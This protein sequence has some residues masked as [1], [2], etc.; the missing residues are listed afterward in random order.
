MVT[1]RDFARAQGQQVKPKGGIDLKNSPTQVQV[2]SSPD[3]ENIMLHTL[4]ATRRGGFPP[5]VRQI[6]M[7]AAIENAGYHTKSLATSAVGAPQADA[8][9]VPGALY[10]GHR[11][12]WE[13][14]AGA[15]TIEFFFRTDDLTTAHVGNGDPAPGTH[16]PAPAGQSA[17]YTIKLRPILSKGPIKRTVDQASAGPTASGAHM[18]WQTTNRWGGAAA[19]HAMPFLFALRN[20]TSGGVTVWK[21]D[22]CHHAFD[23]GSGNWQLIVVT[24]TIFTIEP[25]IT[26]HCIGSYNDAVGIARLRVGQLT[27]AQTIPTYTYDTLSYGPFTKALATPTPIQVFDCPMEIMDAPIT[28]T[29]TVPPGL[30]NVARQ[31]GTYFF[32]AKRFEGALE[33]ITVHVGDVL[34]SV[35]STLDRSTKYDPMA[36]PATVRQHW[37]FTQP[38]MDYVQE[39][40]GQ[41]NHLYFSPRGPIFDPLSG[42][43]RPAGSWWFNGQTSYALAKLGR[44][45]AGVIGSDDG[46][47]NWRYQVTTRDEAAM[48]A[49]VH[50]NL[51][52]G[53]HVV[54]T[55]DS[56]HESFEQVIAEMHSVL[57]VA[58]NTDGTIV[59]YCR[60]SSTNAGAIAVPVYQATRVQSSGVVKAGE[61]YEVTLLR[62]NA[63]LRLRL[64]IN[65]ALDGSAVVTA[66]NVDSEP[67]SGL[68]I[69]AGSFR[70]TTYTTDIATPI[71]PSADTGTNEDINTDHRSHFCGRVEQVAV[72]VGGFKLP[73]VYTDPGEAEVRIEQAR[74]WESPVGGPTRTILEPD[75]PNDLVSQEI[76]PG[77]VVS[78]SGDI[79]INAPIR[80]AIEDAGTTNPRFYST[81][82]AAPVGEE[83]LAF[84]NGGADTVARQVIAWYVLGRWVL[85][86]DDRDERDHGR[87]LRS[88]ELRNHTTTG[89]VRRYFNEHRAIHVQGS[90]CQDDL[91][92]LAALQKRCVESDQLTEA[93]AQFTLAPWQHRNRPFMWKHPTELGPKWAEGIVFPRAD[94]N[95]ITLL[96][97]FEPEKTGERLLIAAASRQLYWVRD[98]WRLDSPFTSEVT[99]RVPFGFGSP[100]SHLRV[101]GTVSQQ[102]FQRNSGNSLEI[103][104]WLKP[105]NLHGWRTLLYKGNLNGRFNF[106]VFF[107]D[108]SLNVM[109]TMG[110][111]QAFWLREGYLA[112]GVYVP[113]V[114]MMVNRWNEIT[115][116]M[117]AATNTI[118]AVVN[119]LAVTFVLNPG[120]TALGTSANDAANYTLYLMGVPLDGYMQ[121]ITYASPLVQSIQFAGFCG[122]VTDVSIRNVL[123]SGQAVSR[124]RQVDG[125]GT[126]YLLPLNE[127]AG[128]TVT[129][130]AALAPGNGE[131]RLDELVL[132]K[133][134]LDE[135]RGAPYR[136]VVYRDRLYVTNGRSVPTSV[137]FR[138]FSHPE[139]AFSVQRV[140]MRQPHMEINVEQGFRAGATYANGVYQ[141][142]LAFENE[143]GIL[144]EPA[145]IVTSPSGGTFNSLYMNRLPRSFDPQVVARQFYLNASGGGGAPLLAAR[146]PDNESWDWEIAPPTQGLAVEATGRKLPAPRA[147]GITVGQGSL[148]LIDLTELDAGQ[149]AF[150]VSDGE[151]VIWWPG[152]LV[153]FVDSRDGKRI[154]SIEAQLG[155]VYLFKRDSSWNE[156]LAGAS[157]PV[158][159][160]VNASVGLAGGVTIYDNLL[161]GAGDKGVYAFDGTSVQYQSLALEGDYR[162]IIDLDDEGLRAMSGAYW[163]PNSQYWISMRETGRDSN[164]LIYVLHTDIG[165]QIG[166]QPQHAWTKLRVPEHTAMASL[167]D[168]RRKPILLLGTVG[169]QILKYDEDLL[170]DG[171]AGEGTLLG[172]ATST[173]LTS[174]T[175]I[176]ATFDTKL[177]GLR[178]AV[179]EITDGA[180]VYTRTIERNTATT[181]FWIDPIAG[182][183]QT[184]SFLIGGFDSFWTTPWISLARFGSF[185]KAQQLD[186]DYDPQVSSLL[187]CHLQAVSGAVT[188]Q[189]TFPL[190]NS[191]YK[192][193]SLDSGYMESPFRITGANRGRFVRLRFGQKKPLM[194]FSVNAWQIRGEES[195]QR[196]GRST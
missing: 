126:Y 110:S 47:P 20:F 148:W 17:P 179:V 75:D 120:W 79:Q 52:H 63:G 29:P 31:D 155:R 138:R 125:A 62:D 98:I 8:L 153:Q 185:T 71:L 146:L 24:S 92:V 58:I 85:N 13:E 122:L 51:P 70:S 27:D 164:R 93:D 78:V 56:E 140:G 154:A 97:A 105:F 183:G 161:F 158:P 132:L 171:C 177:N 35:A 142:Y 196:G 137:R 102:E 10:A 130:N 26:Y 100:N 28:G 59:G 133:E 101:P 82:A 57:R 23:P 182:L 64:F 89:G 136:S 191:E 111:T 88:I 168:A 174:L 55:P 165:L 73:P 135:S 37:C 65:G 76:G 178:G 96:T 123:S 45:I 175:L 11:P 16:P 143:D 106:S 66:V 152:E 187:D 139:G 87:Y 94:Q 190:A 77:G 48:Q 5:L 3:S 30:F 186:L 2:D 124:S 6:P 7:A 162:T 129:Q 25:G 86:A 189:R 131:V 22:F 144:S 81:P 163:W 193:L 107:Q 128:W 38:G 108:G 151:E 114:T 170:V 134:G 99:T 53:L 127:G 159:T 113:R 34:A 121:R 12:V 40:T 50:K 188:P 115:I 32:N 90:V 91:G 141:A 42:S 84:G 194:P 18:R 1:Q 15:M 60:D 69:G 150:A 109:G 49:I 43:A 80:Y 39:M 112:G 195:G 156:N 21:L 4:S 72:I 9:I 68:T 118:T 95:P 180:S 192:L 147:R 104:A 166:Q 160:N 61:R 74:L 181:L 157:L 19:T 44:N 116:R 83:L 169:G 176:G 36:L 67:I 172:T 119:G 149:N 46:N 184:P 103:H 173:S 54:F 33:E 145:N 41:G 14:L 117:N 167:L